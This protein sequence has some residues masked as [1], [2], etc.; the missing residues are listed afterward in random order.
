[1][2][3]PVVTAADSFKISVNCFTRMSEEHVNSENAR[4]I[5]RISSTFICV[6]FNW[7]ATI[8]CKTLFQMFSPTVFCIWKGGHLVLCIT[9]FRGQTSYINKRDLAS[10]EYASSPF[11]RS[12][13][14]MRSQAQR[15][16]VDQREITVKE[17]IQR[18]RRQ[19]T[20][21]KTVQDS[22]CDQQALCRSHCRTSEL[23]AT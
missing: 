19:R 3:S 12:R 20:R 17:K 7:V 10:T 21:Q 23:V 5:S 16:K 1:M 22:G 18:L 15:S 4:C 11:W 6:S 8:F 14:W 2:A 9:N 13:G